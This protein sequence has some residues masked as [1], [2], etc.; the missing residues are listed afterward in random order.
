M[1]A[2]CRRDGAQAQ[3]SAIRQQ[4][5]SLPVSRRLLLSCY[6]LFLAHDDVS[7]VVPGQ[8]RHTLLNTVCGGLRAVDS[9]DNITHHA[10]RKQHTDI[11]TRAHAR[12]R[13]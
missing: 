1:F 3:H 10:A 5:A 11:R 9:R 2:Y 7:V 4:A 6:S 13:R 8:E 12:M